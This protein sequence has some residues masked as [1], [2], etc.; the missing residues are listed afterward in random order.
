MKGNANKTKQSR[1]Y[2]TRELALKH[3]TF[4]SSSL[5]Q[6]VNDEIQ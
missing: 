3:S 1:I 5:K 6:L 4:T 2:F